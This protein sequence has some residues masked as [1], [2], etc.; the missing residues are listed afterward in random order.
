LPSKN[1]Y[2]LKMELPVPDAL[3]V[4]LG[5]CKTIRGDDY[6]K[7]RSKTPE[8]IAAAKAKLAP[9]PSK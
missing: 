4:Q 5:K 3:K 9:L 1:N 6:H 7:S 8:E 2:H